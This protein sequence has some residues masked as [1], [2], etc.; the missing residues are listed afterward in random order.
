MELV[1]NFRNTP[2][3]AQYMHQ[4][5]ETG[6]VKVLYIDDEPNNL[7]S[8][9][10]N[11]R[12]DY[13][14]FIAESTNEGYAILKN[15]PDIRVVLCDQRMPDTTGVEFFETIATECPSPVRMLISGYIDMKSMIKAI[16][17]G[18]IYHYINKPWQEAKL[19]AAIEAGCKYY[20]ETLTLAQKNE[21][22]SQAY[23]EAGQLTYRIIWEA[24]TSILSLLD[25]IGNAES[26]ADAGESGRLLSLLTEV[27]EQT[28]AYII[29]MQQ[30]YNMISINSGEA[31]EP[32]Q[33]A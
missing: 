3:I 2:L 15:H 27:L 31:Q 33:V 11:F 25:T 28:S 6:K 20:D 29:D 32:T 5:T 21:A 30:C 18:R 8:F 24:H 17:H 10:A 9:K 23:R 12:T 16:N 14:V 19:R 4:S 13:Q 1:K 22:L 7:I 26:I